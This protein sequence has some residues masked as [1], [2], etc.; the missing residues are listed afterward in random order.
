MDFLTY[1]RVLRRR[2]PMVLGLTLLAVLLAGITSLM[3]SPTYQ[4]TVRFF[5]S[6]SDSAENSSQL[7]SGNTFAQQRVNSYVQLVSTPRVLQPVIEESD[8]NLS[9]SQLSR[10]V[11]GSVPPQSVI[12]NVNV[13]DGD[14]E[15]AFDIASAVASTLPRTIEAL[16]RVNENQPSPVRMSVVAEAT[17]PGAPIAPNHV[18]NLALGL[19]LGLLIGAG[20]AVLREV[21]DNKVRDKEDLEAITSA[22][23]LGAIP[24]DAEAAKQQNA[25]QVDPQSPW[26]ESFR[27]LRTNLRFVDAAAHPRV[28]VVTSSMPGEGKSTSCANLALMLA[29]S[30]MKTCVI[31]ADLRRPKLLENLGVSGSIGLTDVLIGQHNLYDVLQPYG[32][33][34]LQVLGAGTLPPNPSELLGSE[35][36]VE[37][38]SKLR[39]E[40][41]YVIVDAP[42]LLPVTDAAVLATVVD[43]AILV[44]G[45]GKVTNDHVD[46]S[47]EAIEAVSGNLLGVVL[48]MMPRTARSG[49]DSY[50]YSYNYTTDPAKDP[51]ATRADRRLGRRRTKKD[52]TEPATQDA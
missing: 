32:R 30:G 48:N 12:L 5:V 11:R 6:T 1:A 20:V 40:F 22:T 21:T 23:L 14:A 36:M 9:V 28:M 2:W 17:R 52:T 27:T 19:V 31:E 51:K 43:G 13:T 44:V 45:S 3:T 8:L 50:S 4:S 33:L 49:Y 37:V 15:R 46:R 29:Q 39:E 7:A 47:I 41:D 24:L 42:P 10:M 25:V 34:P 38:L 16:E 18:R 35:A 26:A